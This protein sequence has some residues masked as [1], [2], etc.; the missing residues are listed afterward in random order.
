[1]SLFNNEGQLNAVS[2]RDALKELIKYASVLERNQSANQNI[3]GAPSFTEEQKD[4]L[5][6]R[7][8]NDPEGKVALANAMSN[9]IR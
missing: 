3:A 8:M 7:A 6:R 9:P 4:E 5:V 2:D 1:M